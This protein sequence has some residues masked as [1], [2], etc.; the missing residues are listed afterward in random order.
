MVIQTEEVNC[1]SSPAAIHKCIMD[2]TKLR[3]DKDFDDKGHFIRDT[4]RITV[5]YD[6]LKEAVANREILDK[7]DHDESASF[8]RLPARK[9]VAKVI[10]QV[11]EEGEDPAPEKKPLVARPPPPPEPKKPKKA[12]EEKKPE[13]KKP[14]EKK[15]EEPEPE[16]EEESEEDEEPAPDAPPPSPLAPKAKPPPPKEKKAEPKVAPKPKPKKEYKP[17]E[18]TKEEG[19]K[20][21]PAPKPKKKEVVFALDKNRSSALN[22]SPSTNVLGG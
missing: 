19:E 6:R 2:G 17:P 22:K 21:K 4:G 16:E 12:P 10:K 3:N 14:E 1:H 9:S 7:D 20:P 5:S 11:E 13:E 18:K 8:A 15:P